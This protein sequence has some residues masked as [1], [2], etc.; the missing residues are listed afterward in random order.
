MPRLEFNIDVSEDLFEMIGGAGG[1]QRYKNNVWNRFA[2]DSLRE[3][4]EKHHKLR[5][6]Y[7]FQYSRQKAYDYK[8]RSKKWFIMRRKYYKSQTDL[9]ASGAMQAQI[10]QARSIS[11]AGS[12]RGSEGLV[13]KLRMRFRH[14]EWG[15]HQRG[16]SPKDMVKEVQKITDR[17]KQEI[18][19]GF[20][21]RLIKRA[22]QFRRIGRRRFYSTGAGARG[23]GIFGGYR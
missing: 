3:E 10:T 5:V 17:E 15:K 14:K 7:H 4:L 21:N 6:P 11:V 13:G 8:R 19:I 22:Q 1:S 23:L 18:N 2:A 9:K 20:G 16:V 12:W